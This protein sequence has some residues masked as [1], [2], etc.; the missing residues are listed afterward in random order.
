M[1]PKQLLPL[2][3]GRTMLQETAARLNDFPDKTD[4]CLVVC[5]EAHRFLAAEQLQA[6]DI[7][8]QFILEPAGRNTAPAVALAAIAANEEGE[9]PILLIMP[10]DHVIRD[11]KAFHA[12]ISEGAKAAAEGKLVTFGVVPTGPETGYGYIEAKVTSAAATPVNAFVEK[13]NL[14]TAT[15]YVEGGE[16]FW[17]SGMFMFACDKYLEELGKHAPEMLAAC[18]AAMSAADTASEFI[19]PSGE[20][21]L[22]CPSDSIDYAVM[23]KTD[24]AMVVPLDAGWSDV[25]SWSALHDVLDCDSDNNSVAGDTLMHD[26]RNTYISS[27]NRLVAAAGVDDLV[28]VET[29]DAVLVARKSRSQEVKKLVDMLQEGGREEVNLHRQV[30]RPWGN[31]DSIDSGDGFQVKRLIVSP[32]SVLSLQMHHRRA[33]HWVVVRGTARITL[34]DDV[35]DLGVNEYVHIPI[36][37]THRIENPGTEEVHIIE[38]QCGDYLGEDDIVRFEDKYGREGTNT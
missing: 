10:A 34:N 24:N 21:F 9:S 7:N 29:K 12:A 1:L 20:E 18:Q 27:E 6:I 14:E 13:P 4:R 3:G 28:I 16:H 17:N 22:T 32:G 23:E 35:F 36:G 31:Y 5:N 2:V 37:A 25:G 38:V 26:C 11:S 19:R 30:F 33:E 15:R 8:A